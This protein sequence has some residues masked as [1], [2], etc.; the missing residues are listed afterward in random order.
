MLSSKSGKCAAPS[1]ALNFW[2][3]ALAG[4][5]SI[6]AALFHL[7]G[8]DEED[9]GYIKVSVFLR[10]K[11]EE[12]GAVSKR[13][14]AEMDLSHYTVNVWGSFRKLDQFSPAK[15]DVK[16]L[17]RRILKCRFGFVWIL[18]LIQN[19]VDDHYI[20]FDFVINRVGK[21]FAQ[22]TVKTKDFGVLLREQNQ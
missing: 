1:A 18:T 2:L 3:N 21:A 6:R 8:R 12:T 14:R 4:D 20:F 15:N 13:A 9:Q 10:L 16:S 5:Q 19:A 22:Q 11:N 17:V 7:L